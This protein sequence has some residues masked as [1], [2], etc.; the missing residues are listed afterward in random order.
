MSDIKAVFDLIDTEKNE[1]VSTE[2]VRKCD[3]LGPFAND[4]VAELDKLPSKKANYEQ[5]KEIID[6]IQK[7]CMSDQEDS[8]CV[9]A[10][11]ERE[12]QLQHEVAT[13]QAKCKDY[14]AKLDGLEKMI[15]KLESQHN[16][17]DDQKE[18]KIM[19]LKKKL[20]KTE[21]ENMQKQTTI[22]NLRKQLEKKQQP[23][24]RNRAGSVSSNWDLT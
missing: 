5:F 18:S 4:I 8:M 14:E 7:S 20:D 23:F 19:E 12:V 21:S 17:K 2:E 3:A 15:A 22:D 11:S 6:N 1:H 24:T 10:G 16:A 13:L 9:V